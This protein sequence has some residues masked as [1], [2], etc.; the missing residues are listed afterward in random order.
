MDTLC[1][2]HMYQRE[3]PLVTEATAGFPALFPF[4]FLLAN[5]AFANPRKR[6]RAFIFTGY[7]L[8]LSPSLSLLPA[9]A[10]EQRCSSSETCGGR[11]IHRRER[12]RE[13]E[14]ER[15]RERFAPAKSR[16]TFSVTARRERGKIV[17]RKP[18][19]FVLF[20]PSSANPPRF[21]S[22]ANVFCETD[23]NERWSRSSRNARHTHNNKTVTGSGKRKCE[24]LSRGVAAI[25]SLARL[26][27]CTRCSP[28][29]WPDRTHYN[30]V[31]NSTNIL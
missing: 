6:T 29:N 17:V 19:S 15:E 14:R 20:V 31:R 5:P 25:F 1:H 22:R 9:G 24:H 8:S 30:S 2:S 4:P 26:I 12:K 10:Q 3:S 11:L 13:R 28:N 16:Q 18:R 7:S 27:A 21:T 23:T